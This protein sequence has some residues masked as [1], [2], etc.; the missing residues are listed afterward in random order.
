MID[1]T[2]SKIGED[3]ILTLPAEKVTYYNTYNNRTYTNCS[4]GITLTKTLITHS[5]LEN[6]KIGA[7]DITHATQEDITMQFRTTTGNVININCGEN[8]A[9]L[10]ENVNEG[11]TA[12]DF[13]LD[14][15]GGKQNKSLIIDYIN[16]V[17]IDV[18]TNKDVLDE[19]CSDEEVV[20]NPCPDCPD[21]PECPECPEQVPDIIETVFTELLPEEWVQSFDFSIYNSGGVKNNLKFYLQETGSPSISV[22][23]NGETYS[24]TRAGFQYV[25]VTV[26]VAEDVTEYEIT[27]S[28]GTNTKTFSLEVPPYIATVY[29]ALQVYRNIQTPADNE[30][31]QE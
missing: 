2:I 5:Y 13:Y 1:Y 14:A 6:I 12:T 7:E 9:E 31:Q 11:I 19:L 23:Y 26:P 25:E 24:N 4:N 22:E 17:L 3:I 28:D 15:V 18:Y 21:C 30:E 10:E 27:L 29:F 8:S 16:T 20:A